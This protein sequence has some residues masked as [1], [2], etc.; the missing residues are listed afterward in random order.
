MPRERR[1]SD[2]PLHI[3][4]IAGGLGLL[5]LA[6]GLWNGK[7]RAAVVAIAA[8]CLIG[9]ARLAYGLSAINAAIDLVPAL[10]I[11]GNLRAFPRGVG[12]LARPPSTDTLGPAAGAGVYA[13]Y[14]IADIGAREGTE[15]DRAVASAGS[16]LPASAIVAGTASHPGLVING[17]IALALVGGWVLLR[18]LLRPAAG[19]DGH[20]ESERLRAAALV[21]PRVRLAGPVRAARGQAFHFAAGGLLAY[22]V[23]RGD[24]GRLR[25]TR[26]PPGQRARDPRELRPASP[27]SAAGTS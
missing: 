19:E 12:A 20:D 18:G 3:L 15:L 23:I 22:R 21:R 27:Q 4:G 11:L 7:R 24:R 8:L 25:A 16:H 17:A 13:L 2:L 14:A 1:L 10:L 5:L 9:I 6:A 26:R